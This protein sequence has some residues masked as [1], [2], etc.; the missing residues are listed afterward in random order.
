MFY[1]HHIHNICYILTLSLVQSTLSTCHKPLPQATPD[2]V[3]PVSIKQS[4]CGSVHLGVC[5]R[6]FGTLFVF[7]NNKVIRNCNLS[8]KRITAVITMA[9]LNQTL[10]PSSHPIPSPA[11]S[12]IWRFQCGFI[13]AAWLSSRVLGWAASL[14]PW[15]LLGSLI[16]CWWCRSR[17]RFRLKWQAAV[18]PVFVIVIPPQCIYFH[19]L[20]FNRLPY[21]CVFIIF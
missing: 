16:H 17:E 8:A 13:F 14:N 6:V 1:F 11:F 21:I 15:I 2:W 4:L 18:R 5:G 12:F 3:H 7:I 19:I 9:T 20:I 10:H